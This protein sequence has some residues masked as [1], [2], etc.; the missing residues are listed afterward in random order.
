MPSLDCIHNLKT[1]REKRKLFSGILPILRTCGAPCPRISRSRYTHSSILLS[2]T[3]R[4]SSPPLLGTPTPRASRALD[5]CISRPQFLPSF[6]LLSLLLR[7]PIPHTSGAL[8][9]HTPDLG[10]LILHTPTLHSSVLPHSIILG[11]LPLRPFENEF[12]TSF[13]PPPSQK[14]RTWCRVAR[15]KENDSQTSFYQLK[16][17][18]YNVH[19]I[20]IDWQV[21][22]IW[23]IT[24]RGGT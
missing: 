7:T 20:R 6:I 11:I 1:N 4:Y 10:I 19:N 16:C 8:Y 12:R 15:G 18:R 9:P 21:V 24:M 17:S 13:L 5:P 3:P 2:L 14:K 23:G 22:L